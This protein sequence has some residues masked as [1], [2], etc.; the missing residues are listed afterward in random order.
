MPSA[1]RAACVR[2]FKKE[3]DG[4]TEGL[5]VWGER[6]A[7]DY[8]KRCGFRLV[9]TNFSAPIGQRRDGRLVTGEIDIVAYDV[10]TLPPTLV[11]IEVKTR[12]RGDVATPE[13]AVGR[14]KQRQIVRV[15]RVY[16]RLLRVGD[17]PYRYDVL[18]VIA[19]PSGKGE[20]S[21]LRGYFTDRARI[22]DG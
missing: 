10:S 6:L 13:A 4:A 16:R 2:L 17:E 3:K 22:R 5:G 20:C 9:L 7:A 14:R 12:T 21:L 15:A 8:L 19:G 18:S 1:I 11:F